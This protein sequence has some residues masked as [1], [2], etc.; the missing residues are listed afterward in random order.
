MRDSE[1][2]RPRRRSKAS[3]FSARAR[4]LCADLEFQL[5]P[6]EAPLNYSEPPSLKWSILRYVFGQDGGPRCPARGT[7]L[8][9]GDPLTVR[10]RA[11]PEHGRLRRARV[12][13]KIG[14]Q[15]DS[16]AIEPL[17]FDPETA[18]PGPAGDFAFTVD[19]GRGGEVSASVA[20]TSSAPA[21]SQPLQASMRRCGTGSDQRPVRPS[22]V[23]FCSSSRRA[24]L[25]PRQS[26]GSGPRPSRSARH[27]AHRKGEE[28]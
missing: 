7:S 25:R 22:C 11:V 12:V 5:P 9:D 23:P 14:D 10:I 28:F 3:P 19:D 26:L 18:P 1:T 21:R 6:G 4:A 13:L 20:V 17:T 15:L 24:H 8:S 2:E 16:S 27:Q